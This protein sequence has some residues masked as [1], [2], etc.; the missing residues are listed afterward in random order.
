M[1][2][3]PISAVSDLIKTTIDKIFPD[4]NQKAQAQA[5]FETLRATQ[6]FQLLAGQLQVNLAEAGSTNWW[7]AGWRPAVGWICVAGLGI[8]Y[9]VF[10]LVAIFGVKLPPLDVGTLMGLLI[11]M[12]GIAGMRTYEKVQGAEGNR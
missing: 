8:E 9:L 12:L 2:L 6:D 7:V 5:A 1:S 11:P 10:P 4:A 3:D